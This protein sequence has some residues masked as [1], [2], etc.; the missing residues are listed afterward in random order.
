MPW[1]HESI[2]K[3]Y[4]IKSL[5]TMTNDVKT[6]TVK[7]KICGHCGYDFAEFVKTGFL[8]CSEC[9]QAFAQELECYLNEFR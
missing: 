2:K 5:S 1:D 6:P 7:S 9:Y 4:S 3:T 8:G